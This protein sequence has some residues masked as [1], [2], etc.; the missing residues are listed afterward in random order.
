MG[1]FMDYRCEDGRFPMSASCVTISNPDSLSSNASGVNPGI[2][3][4]K[5]THLNE[6]DAKKPL[7]VYISQRGEELGLYNLV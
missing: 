1:H 4:W 6:L 5:S 3:S 2:E 7:V